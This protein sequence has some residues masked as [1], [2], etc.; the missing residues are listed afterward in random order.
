MILTEFFG[1][2]LPVSYPGGV[3]RPYDGSAD[4]VSAGQPAAQQPRVEL[5]EQNLYRD[6]RAG[7]RAT[8]G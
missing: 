2:C 4:G 1:F 3:K 6:R 7:G 8:F 5:P